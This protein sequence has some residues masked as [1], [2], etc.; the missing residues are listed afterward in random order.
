MI[1]VIAVV[2]VIIVIIAGAVSV[3]GR[4][5]QQPSRLGVLNGIAI[6]LLSQE[7][8]AVGGEF[9]IAGIARH[10]RIK[11]RRTTILFGAQE[12]SKP[13]RLLLA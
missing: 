9:L 2:I 3:H 12:P 5:Y 7:K 8:L 1:V 10:N 13:L 6:T 11:V 4:L